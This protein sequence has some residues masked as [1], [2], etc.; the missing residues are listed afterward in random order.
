[1]SDSSV[2]V[3]HPLPV[4]QAEKDED[5][6]ANH[7]YS[8]LSASKL[9]E[10]LTKELKTANSVLV[11][12][13]PPEAVREMSFSNS[14][15]TLLNTPEAASSDLGSHPSPSIT[16]FMAPL[17]VMSGSSFGRGANAQYWL[18]R[19]AVDSNG[20]A[21]DY[22]CHFDRY[23]KNDADP[24]SMVQRLRT[25]LESKQRVKTWLY[26]LEDKVITSPDPTKTLLL[27]PFAV[28]EDARMEH[29]A[30]ASFPDIMSGKTRDGSRI[31]AST[32]LIAN[33]V[34]GYLEMPSSSEDSRLADGW[35]GR[36][37][38]EFGEY[39]PT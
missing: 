31:T 33:L 22:G 5:E 25:H 8:H 17:I 32:R 2:E 9:C 27:Q 29:G 10:E 26:T 19:C 7:V 3:Y 38:K 15:E 34:E 16:T 4:T 11:C 30:W 14:A 28:G 20:D 6:A 35:P 39:G 13:R 18:P 12:N 24:T 1:M 36:F 37:V 23:S 21:T